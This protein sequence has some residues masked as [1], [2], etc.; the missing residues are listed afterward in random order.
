MRFIRRSNSILPSFTNVFDEIFN[1]EFFGKSANTQ[2]SIPPVNVKETEK[3]FSLEVA[4]PGFDKEDINIQVK[5]D[6]LTIES[7]KENKD[8][9]VEKDKFTRREFSFRSFR[10]IF[11]LP[12]K[13]NKDAIK[14]DYKNGILNVNIPKQDADVDAKRIDIG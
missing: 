8:E 10:R 4:V 13:V 7:K 9:V 2:N 14:A 11:S 12:K 5:D 6:V 1:D 3:D